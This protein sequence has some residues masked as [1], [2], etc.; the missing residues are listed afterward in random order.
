VAKASA[1][2]IL[3][4]CRK[5]LSSNRF[6]WILNGLCVLLFLLL[7]IYVRYTDQGS[8]SRVQVV[9]RLF[10]ES[11]NFEYPYIGLL[12]S[13]SEVL[14]CISAS[15]CLFGFSVT[16]VISPRQRNNWFLLL[17]AIAL[18]ILLIDDIFRLTLMTTFYLGVPKLAMYVV[19]GMFFIF[20]TFTFSKRLLKTPYLLL[21][22]ALFL[23]ALSG[24]TDIIHL[25]GRGAP[26]I[27]EDGTKLLGLLNLVLYF[28]QVSLQEI[29]AS[30]QHRIQNNIESSG[31]LPS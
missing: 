1:K 20:Y 8:G 5:Q 23:F 22:I 21:L 14:W 3:Q 29:V 26:I 18:I 28:W 31:R 17:S 16:K 25:E 24:M 10:R 30:I 19:Y 12:T 4:A 11:F 15:I 27:L 2:Q 9:S 6:F 13:L 7:L